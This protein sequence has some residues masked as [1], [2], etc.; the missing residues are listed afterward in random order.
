MHIFSSHHPKDGRLSRARMESLDAPKWR[1]NVS[2]GSLL[3]GF[4]STR[5]GNVRDEL[6][7]T[8]TAPDNASVARTRIRELI[9]QGE[10]EADGQLP[11]ERELCARFGVSRRSVRRALDA[12][13]TEGLV[14]RRQGKGT[15]VGQ[16]PDPNG[17]LAAIIAPDTD[18]LSVMEARLVLEP[19]L[20]ALAARRATGEDVARMRALA[21]RVSQSQDARCRGI[22]GRL[23][24]PDHR[25]DRGQSDPQHRLHD[26]QRGTAGTALATRTP[27]GAV[28]L[29]LVA[30]YGRQHERIIDAIHARDEDA[31]RA[32]MRD[33]LSALKAN[34][35]RVRGRRPRDDRNPAA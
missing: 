3:S 10:V 30:E 23:A 19:E 22:V 26:H 1:T 32:A 5:G 34:L 6:P 2:N 33:H 31:A 4:G 15:F 29:H 13:E 35:E 12:L 27:A 11:T 25:A 24:A 21:D 28:A 7:D 18:P 14:W 9:R 20:A 8:D 17:H 16:P